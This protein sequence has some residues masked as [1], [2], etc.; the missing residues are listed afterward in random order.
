MAQ[1]NIYLIV[2]EGEKN[3]TVPAKLR[4]KWQF[5]EPVLDPV[6]GEPT[7]ETV[8]V[9]PS[10]LGAANRLRGSFGEVREFTYGGAPFLL[11]E[12]ELSWIDG[13]VAEVERLQSRQAS[14]K[15][16][17]RL[18]TNSEAQRLLAGEDIFL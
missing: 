11:V 15:A 13:E 9:H 16:H 5:Q 17:Y 12:L 10:W 18:L 1:G 14:K 6:T 4:D 3:S 2:P 7:G 8:L